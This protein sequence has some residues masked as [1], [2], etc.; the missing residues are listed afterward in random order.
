M[1]FVCVSVFVRLCLRMCVCVCEC[2][3]VCECVCVCVCMCVSVCVYVY[4]HYSI[5]LLTISW[6]VLNLWFRGGGR[7]CSSYF[8]GI[9]LPCSDV[10]FNILKTH[11]LYFLGMYVSIFICVCVCV[12]L[13]ERECVISVYIF[14]YWVC[15]CVCM[16][17][18]YFGI[19]VRPKSNLAEFLPNS[20]WFIMISYWINI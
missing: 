10:L 1:K 19:F 16:K 11:D 3:W 17:C 13:W 9:F 20:I 7:I 14:V 2:V 4:F 5:C 6:C 15:V 8:T 18:V 12:C